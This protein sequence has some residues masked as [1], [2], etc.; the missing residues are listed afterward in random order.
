M[1]ETADQAGMT[2]DLGGPDFVGP[3][4]GGPDFGG[5]DFG[6]PAFGGPDFG[7]QSIVVKNA[8]VG[9]WCCESA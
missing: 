2:P 4:L 7:G 1:T 6:V 3:D 5:P 8:K 9:T